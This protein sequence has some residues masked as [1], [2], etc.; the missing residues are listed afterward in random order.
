[1][2][3]ASGKTQ[4]GSDEQC[5]QEFGHA[6]S[7]RFNYGIARPLEKRT[8]KALSLHFSRLRAARIDNSNPRGEHALRLT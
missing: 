3:R 6:I 8:K 1:L 5:N 7:F 2:R 4:P